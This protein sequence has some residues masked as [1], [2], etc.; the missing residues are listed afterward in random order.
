MFFLLFAHYIR[1]KKPRAASAVKQRLHFFNR[2]GSHSGFI[3]SQ[4]QSSSSYRLREKDRESVY[5]YNCSRAF[6]SH[7]LEEKLQQMSNI[8][9]CAF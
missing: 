4:V 3:S 6:K 5:I 8:R 9:S 7:D 2:E 1:R